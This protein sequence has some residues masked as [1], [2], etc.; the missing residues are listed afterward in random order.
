MVHVA[1]PNPYR[2]EY[3][4]QTPEECAELC[5][6]A[7]EEAILFHGPES[8]S[9]VIAE[10][11]SQ[12]LGGVVPGPGYF[13]R[14][15]DICDR[16]G[17]LLIVD[18]V[19]TVFGRTGKWFGSGTVGVTPASLPIATGR[20]GGCVRV[21]GGVG[22]GVGVDVAGGVGVGV[23]VGGGPP[24]VIVGWGVGVG[25]SPQMMMTLVSLGGVR[26]SVFGNTGSENENTE[27]L[28][29]ARGSVFE[30]RITSVN[31]SSAEQVTLTSTIGPV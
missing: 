24:G 2:C 1:H 20:S 5:A 21:G 29:P 12:P 3:G 11:V 28:V 27:P 7:I 13:E 16:Y 19:I 30:R 10:P 23:S 4:G 6:N 15:R 9:A 17:V 25:G 14:V 8:V 31:V 22:P 26:V 18:E